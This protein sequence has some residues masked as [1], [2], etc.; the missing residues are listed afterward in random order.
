[1][2]VIPAKVAGVPRIVV[3]T[4]PGGF[5]E[6]PIFAAALVELNVQEIYLIDGA[7]AIAA[8]ACGT[9]TIP[10]VDKI[11]GG[12]GEYVAAAKRE[13]FGD[14]A[15]DLIAG[16]GEVVVLATAESNPRFVAADM[17]SQAEHDESACAV[18]FTDSEAHAVMVKRELELQL[19]SLPR[20]KIASNSLQNFGAVVVL[21]S[22]LQAVEWINEIA[23]EQIEVFSSVSP[24]AVD[25]ITHA[26]SIFYG[27]HSPEAVGDYF[28]GSNHVRPTHGA[29]RFFSPLG[30][31]DFQRRT[32]TI[33]YSSKALR[34]SGTSIEI[35]ARAEGM[36]GHARSVEIRREDP[37]ASDAVDDNG[38]MDA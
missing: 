15:I 21:E 8:L 23:P 16:A 4:P 13:V 28:A 2:S 17:L 24:M 38:T 35:L 5:Y 25:R 14:V 18:C 32:S 3:V 22:S 6:S 36:E 27:D 37:I 1:M 29:A 10:R 26:G 19:E 7:P 31:Y 20:Q 9:E 34:D 30:V 12:G 11:V 33:R